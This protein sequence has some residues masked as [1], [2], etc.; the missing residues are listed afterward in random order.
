MFTQLQ[1]S[2]VGSLGYE[3]NTCTGVGK[4]PKS[5]NM[6]H[7]QVEFEHL[8]VHVHANWGWNSGYHVHLCR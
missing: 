3:Q 1:D 5:I 7:C 6:L 8:L 2:K 4:D